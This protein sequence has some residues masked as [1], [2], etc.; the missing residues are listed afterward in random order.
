[1][2]ANLEGLPTTH[3]GASTD[4]ASS[5]KVTYRGDRS[6]PMLLV[7]QFIRPFNT[8]IAKSRH[9]RPPGS[10]KLEASSNAKRK[11]DITERVVE[12]MYLYDLAPKKA[13]GSDGEGKPA[14]KRLYFLAGGAWQMTPSSQHWALVTEL[15]TKLPDFIVTMVSYPLAP[16]SPAPVAFPQIMKLYRTL[17]A[18][19][20]AANEE[21]IL[22]GDSAGG[23]II[24]SLVAND[25][26][27][28]AD[29]PCPKA[30]LA[31]SPSTDMRRENKDIKVV[32]KHD[33]ILR[34]PFIKNSAK[35]WCGDWD[36]SD[37][38]VSP[39]LAD[40]EPLARRGVQ[41]HGIT[42][43]Y[44]ILSPDGILFREKCKEN[45]IQGEWLEWDKQM[46]DFPLTF[47]Y[48]LKEGVES[49]EWILDVLR[50]SSMFGAALESRILPIPCTSRG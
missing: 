45:N 36:P 11:L 44:D 23:N 20:T 10:Q 14:R 43:L 22:M 30:L 15:A 13:S 40:I 3:S 33:P 19:A 2:A 4:S 21:V 25:L 42:G 47:H 16:K 24:L 28:D 41:V 1:M 32:E 50:R 31:I 12:D 29:A 6:I 35:T 18:D 37:T 8:T 48:K 9:V 39:L 5:I 34:I 17:M 49:V 27:A 38:R 46:H 26:L 7:Q